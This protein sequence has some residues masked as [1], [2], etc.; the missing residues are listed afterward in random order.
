VPEYRRDLA[1]SHNNLGNL[2]TSL[3]KRAEAAAAYRQARALREKLAADF[4][5]VPEH[6]QELATSHNNLGIVLASL[7]KR[8]EAEAVYR[9]ALALREKLTSDYPTVP[10]YRSDPA[11]S[12][13]SLGILL[14][15]LGKRPEAEAEYRQ[16]LALR[17]KLVAD[18]PTVPEYA[19]DLG[20]SYCN[21]GLLVMG[22][23]EAASS[24]AWFA[25]AGATLRPVLAKEPRLV[26][27]RLFL[28]NMHENRALALDQLGRHVEA[29]ADWE[30]AIALN[31]EKPRDGEYRCGR[32]ASLARAGQ[33]AEATAAVE[34]ILKPGNAA[35][36]VLYDAACVYALAAAQAAKQARPNTSSLR[37]EQYARR[38]VALLRQAMQTGYQNVAHMKKD[39]DL[40]ALRDRADFKLLLEQMEKKA[41]G[42]PR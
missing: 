8:P 40:D 21:F 37:A 41:G 13:N 4:P 12:H 38:A 28:R 22:R 18:F 10:D 3:G 20:G 7:G 27:A 15:S 25:K 14:A 36:G 26:T 24:L 5:T 39:A 42:P 6:R 32:A 1:G 9:Q 17:E 23:G 35:N 2:L 33:L 19:L 11:R 29:V 16:V 30:Q 31:D 34:E